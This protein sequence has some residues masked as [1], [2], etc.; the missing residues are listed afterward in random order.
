MA[1]DPRAG[2]HRLGR[3]TAAAAGLLVAFHF[4]SFDIAST[5]LVTDVRY[6]VYYAWQVSEGAVPHLDFFEN[7]PQLSVFLSAGLY[8]LAEALGA[9]PLLVIRAG[10]LA[11]AATAAWLA[12][13]VF[14]RLGGTACGW[15]GLAAS[16]VFG[17]LGALPAVGTL[18]KLAM[19]VLGPAAALLAHRR[20][21][22]WAGTLGGLAFFDWQMGGAAWLAVAV[23]ALADPQDRRRALAAV[24]LGGALA[25]APFAVYYAS[26]G[27]LGAAFDQLIVATLSRGASSL[28]AQ[29][30]S[31][32]FARALALVRVACPE[33]TGWLFAS[34]AGVPV[35]AWLLTAG[36]R[37]AAGVERARLVLPLS[38]LYGAIVAMSAVEVQG[39][40]DLFA[41][42]HA[43]SFGLGLVGWALLE[44]VRR[45]VPAPW[46]PAALA[47]LAVLAARPGPL[48]APLEL[49]TPRIE[50]GASL[51]DQRAVA[52]AAERVVGEAPL[53]A[54]DSSEL[55]FLM[56]RRNA[57]PC[58]YWNRATRGHFRTPADAGPTDTVL[59]LLSESGA[60]FFIAPRH[61]R[62]RARIL[63]GTEPIRLRSTDRR[64]AVELR[65]R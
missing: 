7:K 38:V 35:A 31:A 56:R 8:D 25:V 32:R 21:W 51:A 5:P 3:L 46:A 15:I 63:R 65:E 14:R 12:F 53:A 29:D 37:S 34:A 23:A 2:T 9:D 28:E 54:F 6:F 64:Y 26:Q 57:V 42:L 24:C 44:A 33:Q 59:R 45:Y 61:V 36:R 60:P 22:V 1:S 13:V 27:A 10:Q 55:L 43:A 52:R 40:G 17:L 58:L 18:P 19:M 4:S 49:Q 16:L 20:R 30:L 48:R 39:Y 62:D 50:R 11:L 47:L 41:L